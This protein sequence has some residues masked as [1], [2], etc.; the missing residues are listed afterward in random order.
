MKNIK[1]KIRSGYGKKGKA[2]STGGVKTKDH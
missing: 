1:L 2:L